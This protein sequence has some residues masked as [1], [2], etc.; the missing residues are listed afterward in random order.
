[1][2]FPIYSAM[3]DASSPED[4]DHNALDET[5]CR[6]LFMCLHSCGM[7]GCCPALCFENFM[8]AVMNSDHELWCTTR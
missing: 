4:E 3:K 1:M 2:S 8:A 5:S 7:L 6:H